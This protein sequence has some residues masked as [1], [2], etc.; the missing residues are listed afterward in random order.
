MGTMIYYGG[1]IEGKKAHQ[2]RHYY[3]SQTQY[4][5]LWANDQKQ[6]EGRLVFPGGEFV[7]NWQQDR[8]QGFGRL[9][10]TEG[11]LTLVY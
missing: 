4:F 8:R 3:P 11:P 9:K 6:G 10:K 1:W 2:G 5:G 7:G